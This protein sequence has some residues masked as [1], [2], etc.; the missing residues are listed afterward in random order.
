MSRKLNIKIIGAGP[1]GS[2][3]AIALADSECNISIFDHKNINELKSRNRAYALTHSSRKL[4]EYLNLWTLLK[5]KTNKFSKLTVQDST[6]NRF[7][8]FNL[9]NLSIKNRS[10][11]GIGW[12]INH[13]DLMDVIY[14]K[15]LEYKNIN[16][17]IIPETNYDLENYDYVIAADGAQ[18]KSRINWNIGSFKF[19]YNQCCFTSKVLVRNG[20]NDRAFEVLREEGPFAILPMKDDIYQVVWS[21][22][23]EKCKT[24]KNNNKSYVEIKHLL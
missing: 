2:L 20:E 24:L 21:A 13:I 23:L 5:E 6:V 12:I 22:S 19:K 15:L 4:L 1:T 11:G 14:K 9:S 10:S 3:L 8:N 16:F 18:S 7:I 17:Q